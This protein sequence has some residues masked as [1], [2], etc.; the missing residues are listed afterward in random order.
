[1]SVVDE[2]LALNVDSTKS[3]ALLG[4]VQTALSGAAAE[5]EL[6][7][8][9]TVTGQTANYDYAGIAADITLQGSIIVT[10]STANYD[11]NGLNATI[12]IQGPITL[13]PK[14]TIRVARKS[15]ATRVTRKSNTIRVR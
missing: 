1:M 13:N 7:G 14:N 9:I 10:G 3:S 4:C 11:Y 12:I 6:T 8:L 5:V 2:P 15:N